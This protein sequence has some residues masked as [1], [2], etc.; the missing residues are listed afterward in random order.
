MRFGR[1]IPARFA[2][3]TIVSAVFAAAMFAAAMLIAAERAG[4][5]PAPAEAAPEST[6][7]APPITAQGQRIDLV[8]KAMEQSIAQFEKGIATPGTRMEARQFPLYAHYVFVLE[9]DP[10][11]AEA[12]LTRLLALQ[13]NNPKSRTYGEFAASEGASAPDE[14]GAV[15]EYTVL[16][17]VQVMLRYSEK[18]KPELR[19]ELTERLKPA[20]AAIQRENR[21][22]DLSS[23]FLMNA[24]DE[25]LV[26]E[27]LRDPKAI[28]SGTAKLTQ[29]LG[30]MRSRGIQEYVASNQ[31]AMQLSC[32]LIA[33][34]YT[35]QPEARR[36]LDPIVKFLWSQVA[37]NVVPGRGSMGGPQSRCTDFI[38]GIG[39]IDCFTFLEGLRDT[40]P[41]LVPFGDGLRALMNI[42]ENGWRPD[43]SVR[44][45]AFGERVV[46]QRWGALP[47]MDR[48]FY[49]TND[50]AIGSSSAPASFYDR[51][52]TAEFTTPRLL[53]AIW[54][55]PDPFDAPYG[56]IRDRK[57]GQFRHPQHFVEQIAAVQEKNS[58]LA[59]MNLR[60]DV[61]GKMVPSVATN[62]VF[63][64][65]V[66]EVL[67][68]GK[69]VPM[70]KAF[71]MRATTDS[72][73]V[74]REGTGAVAIR[75]FQI[76]GM[77]GDPPVLQLKFDANQGGVA[78]LVGYHYRPATEPRRPPPE[79]NIRAGVMMLADRVAGP[80]DL[81]NFLARARNAKIE[82][83]GDE[84][85]WRAKL[86][87]GERVLEA[88]LNLKTG[89]ILERKING[90]EY[91][92]VVFRVNDRD[93]AAELLGY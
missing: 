45:L 55:V 27:L 63:P 51:K 19:D 49:V 69:R 36:L 28:S 54:V 4:A 65:A 30:V 77:D 3:A 16:S 7:A 21:V 81:Q 90:Q 35:R 58:V 93:I 48:Y 8:K 29:F 60:Q 44:R 47:G 31:T 59:I 5:Q 11:K 25:L 87:D 42:M 37:A 83:S 33:Q 6:A 2:T 56:Q 50:Y 23:V 68:D 88:G 64:A 80:E 9:Q 13:D 73:L 57:T 15:T 79:Q 67:L 82:Q 46:R 52:L 26:G 91:Q 61:K 12:A 1:I 71:E 74:V 38:F 78:R 39:A 14:T 70:D 53:P 17:L 43:D 34:N 40:P 85:T 84:L 72:I 89:A 22:P 75:L 41:Y 66:D 24:V 10:A 86:T 62:V 20:L 92:P 32:L 76:D 18:L